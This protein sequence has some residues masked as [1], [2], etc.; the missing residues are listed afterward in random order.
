[1]RVPARTL[2]R[3]VVAII[4]AAVFVLALLAMVAVAGGMALLRR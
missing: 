4:A 2:P 1:M 3:G